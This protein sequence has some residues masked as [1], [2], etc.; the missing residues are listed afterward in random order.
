MTSVAIGIDSYS[1]SIVELHLKDSEGGA[2]MNESPTGAAETPNL[3]PITTSVESTIELFRE[4][5]DID[6]ASPSDSGNT[7][8][9][10]ADSVDDQA[11]DFVEEAEMIDLDQAGV[12]SGLG[13]GMRG[14][15]TADAADMV[16]NLSQDGHLRRSD[17]HE[18]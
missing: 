11:P 16:F 14:S 10:M 9:I 15:E 7:N 2:E 18:S 5:E 13:A 12:E 8:A 17:G 4:S 1:S 6:V 3:P